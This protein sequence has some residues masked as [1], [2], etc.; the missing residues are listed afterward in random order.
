[1]KYLNVSE[2]RDIL[3]KKGVKVSYTVVRD[4]TRDPTF[5]EP[6]YLPG[7]IKPRWKEQ[8]VK[9]WIENYLNKEGGKY[10]KT[11]KVS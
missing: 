6:V 11:K 2:I 3:L 4:L 7:Y 5:P 8:E 9:K 10:G 1:M